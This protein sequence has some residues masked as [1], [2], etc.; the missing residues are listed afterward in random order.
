M[1]DREQDKAINEAMRRLDEALPGFSTD[2]PRDKEDYVAAMVANHAPKLHQVLKGKDPDK[3]FDVIKG[4]IL[5]WSTTKN[6][7]HAAAV[8]TVLLNRI[9][10][11]LDRDKGQPD[12]GITQWR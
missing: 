3:D 2:N 10:Q 11:L 6:L 12:P 1:L 7:D 5:R 4:E 9:L 8:Q